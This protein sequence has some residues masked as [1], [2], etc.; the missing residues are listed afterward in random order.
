MIAAAG[1]FQS[2]LG[3]PADWSPGC[4]RSWL[5]DPDGDGTYTW[6]GTG[7]PAGDYEFKIAYDEAWDESYG[8]DGG[9]DNIKFT[10]PA[11]GLTVK[12]SFNRASHVPSVAI[13]APAASTDLTKAK[14]Y[15]LKPNLLAWPADSLP[16]G[17]EP[18]TLRWRLHAAADGGL[19]SDSERIYGDKVYNLDYDPA[20]LP[21]SV[22][23]KYPQLDG[24]VAIKLNRHTK[25]LVRKLLR[26]QVAVG[27]YDDQHK[28]ID[29]TGIQLAGVLDSLYGKAASR[30][31][32][33]TGSG[34]R[35]TFRL[36]AP[37]ARSVDLLTWPAGTADAPVTSAKRTPMTRKADGS[38]SV[39]TAAP[40][41]TRYLYAVRVYVPSTDKVETNLVTDPYSVALTLNSTRSV[42]VN[43]NAAAYK[44][45]VWTSIGSA[46]AQAERRLD[47]LRAARP[48]LLDQRHLGAG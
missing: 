34:A 10:V 18:A 46:E 24:Y 27:L 2:E 7:M 28:I 42:V 37:T 45:A 1:S 17:V 20:G 13:S 14:A 8:A 39:R 38:W 25:A 12:F 19:I 11:D 40:T 6:T 4:L 31:Y 29:G 21:A 30:A 22:V 33:I 44:P 5:G 9:G 48:G 15:W 36:W 26:G 32:G 16:E 23:A 47:D 35:P 43:L 41:G 3:C